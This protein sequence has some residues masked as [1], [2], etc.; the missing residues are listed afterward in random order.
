MDNSIQ[1]DLIKNTNHKMKSNKDK[2]L[3][4]KYDTTEKN[5]NTNTNTKYKKKIKKIDFFL[6]NEI[7]ISEI[8]KKIPYYKINFNLLENY[9]YIKITSI[10]NK[11]IYQNDTI[12]TKNFEKEENE[13]NKENK[14]NEENKENKEKYILCEYNRCK[15]IDF[16]TFIF[17]LPNPKL[18]IFHILDSYKHLLDILT[19][20][21][22]NNVCFFN[23]SSINIHFHD[24]YRPFIKNFE[25]SIIIKETNIYFIDYITNI[26]ENTSDFINKPLEAHVLFYLIKNDEITLSYTLIETICDNYVKQLNILD[27]FH[28]ID[29]NIY[30][31]MCIE[32]LM[33]YINKPKN[34]II[35]DILKNVNT[36]DNYSLSILY[37]HLFCNIIQNF[38]LK[39]T[40]INKLPNILFKN[41]Y[42][43][44]LKRETLKNTQKNYD[45]VFDDFY[46]WNFVNNISCDKMEQMYLSLLN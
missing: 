11:L 37:L 3:Y 7:N 38:S 17:N 45:K 43:N 28:E 46:N 22:E 4:K 39:D 31:K 30:K 9:N 12:Q 35:I 15:S 2:T 26:I 32:S 36:W 10:N 40:F 19:K 5:T 23:L 20:I 14:E 24:N 44:P 16:A 18:F 29:K 27:F 41:I 33:N 13:E 6:Q 21:N 25:K 1:I 34:S 42:P 8:L